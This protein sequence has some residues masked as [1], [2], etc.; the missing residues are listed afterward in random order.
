VSKSTFE[1]FA[2]NDAAQKTDFF[3]HTLFLKNEAQINKNNYATMLFM[4]KQVSL[5]KISSILQKIK[6]SP[7]CYM[8]PFYM[9]AFNCNGPIAL[10]SLFHYL[11]HGFGILKKYQVTA[12]PFYCVYANEKCVF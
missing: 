2:P 8:H 10:L 3:L 9:K 7:K 12:A 11:L 1:G 4:S 6:I 5:P